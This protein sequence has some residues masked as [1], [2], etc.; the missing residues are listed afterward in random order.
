MANKPA[1][2]GLQP[3]A[4]LMPRIQGPTAH[5]EKRQLL[6][7]SRRESLPLHQGNGLILLVPDP[8]VVVEMVVEVVAITKLGWALATMANSPP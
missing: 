4:V 5:R 1:S 6:A 7:V 2:H 3:T 8:V